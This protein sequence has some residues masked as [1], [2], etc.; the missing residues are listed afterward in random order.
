MIVTDAPPSE[1]YR[2]SFESNP[3][4]LMS[5]SSF[6][7]PA[8]VEANRE[9]IVAL[10]LFLVI[11]YVDAYVR[12]EIEAPAIKCFC[13]STCDCIVS[14]MSNSRSLFIFILYVIV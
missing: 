11:A 9:Y 13:L 5:C 10:F 6:R 1:V 3:V 2:R 7:T 14:G 12:P 4:V 8:P